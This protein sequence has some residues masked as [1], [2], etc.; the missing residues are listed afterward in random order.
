[1]ILEPPAS[2]F[3]GASARGHA[4]PSVL[5]RLK[6]ETRPQ[7]DAI[8]AALALTSKTLTVDAYRHTL[9][10]FY[11][12][13]RP[14]E[15]GLHAIADWKERGLDLVE[16]QKTQLLEMDLR[17]LG[18]T[19]PAALPV[20]TDLPPHDTFAAGFGCLYVLEGATLGGLVIGRSV[21]A[22]TAITRD[23]GGRFFYG[24]GDRT[25]PMWQAFRVVL[26]AF[27]MT[28]ADPNEIVSAAQATFSKLQQWTTAEGDPR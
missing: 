15:A 8:E 2:P 9:A 28:C 1:M 24:Y 20:C 17:A 22:A 7:H 18:V 27:A 4:P 14:L 19:N 26:G 11:G 6:T 13:Y 16:R 23:T 25:G 10:R 5:A 12:F 21:R 3:G